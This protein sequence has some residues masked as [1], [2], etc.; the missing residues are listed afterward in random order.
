MHT[1]T[2]V[3]ARSDAA[4]TIYFIGKFRAASVRERR[5]FESGAYLTQTKLSVNI[6]L[7][8]AKETA[9]RDT[10][11]LASAPEADNVD[12]FVDIEEDEEELE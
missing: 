5:L 11:T 8:K 12:P 6:H 9:K 3:F 4:A 2:P 7:Q 10:A 1:L